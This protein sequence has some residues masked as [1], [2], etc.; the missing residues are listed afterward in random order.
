MNEIEKIK[1][2]LRQK[3]IFIR[4]NVKNREDKS[5]IIIDKVKQDIDYQDAKIVALYKSLPSEV[6]TTELIKYSIVIGKVVALPKVVN[7]EL[8][9]YKINS[10]NDNFIKSKFGV[11]EPLGNNKDFISKNNIDLVIVP[12]VCF[13]KEKNRLGFGKGYY[14]GFLKGTDLKT[15]AICFQEQIINDILPVTNDDIKVQK[16]IT[17]KEIYL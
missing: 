1:Q 12:G 3:Y 2:E 8:K 10:L 16:I 15:I 11:E 14:D 4:S 6:D 17:D 7:N 5:R 9:F 13:D